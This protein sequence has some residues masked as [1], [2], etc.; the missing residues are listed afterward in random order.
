M[1]REAFVENGD[2]LEPVDRDLRRAYEHAQTSVEHFVDQYT[3][4]ATLSFEEALNDYERSNR[5]LFGDDDEDAPRK[6]GWRLPS[7]R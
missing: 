1:F 5:L 2:K 4:R 3:E 7:E 6:G